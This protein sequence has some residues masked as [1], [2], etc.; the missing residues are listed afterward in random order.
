MARHVPWS[1]ALLV[2]LAAS[3]GM[4]QR[5][6]SARPASTYLPLNH[7]AYDY[8]NLLGARGRLP[9]L[10]PLVQPYRRV[11]VVAALLRAQQRGDLS[12]EERAWA[13]AL[14]DELALE[15]ELVQG[16][17]QELGLGGEV[18]V[19]FKALSQRHRDPLRPEGDEAVFGTA[20]VILRGAVPGVAGAFH[21]RWDNHYLNDPQFPGGRV[22]EVRACDPLIAECAYRIEEAYLELQAPYVRLF[23]GRMG[24]NWGLPG[25]EG[26]LV[27]N[28]SYTYD[29]IGYRFGNERLAITGLFAP[30]SD[31]GGDTIRYF[32]S[33]RLDWRVR[34]NLVLSAGESVL[35]GGPGQRL[36]LN[37]VNPVNVWEIGAGSKIVER[38]SIGMTEVWWRPRPSVAVYWGLLLDNTKFG[39]PGEASGLTQ[40]GTHAGVQFP[41]VGPAIALRADFSLVNSLAYRNR[42]NRLQFYTVENLGL[43]RDK[44]DAIIASLQGAWFH[45]AELVLKPQLHVMWRGADDI[46]LPWPSDAFTGHD[47]LLV[48]NVET[49]IRPALAGRWRL[50][51]GELEW[52]AGLNL[53]KNE[54]N[55]VQGWNARFVARA[56][57][58]LRTRF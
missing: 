17:E 25:A 33:H 58:T 9:G 15:V 2:T 39:D 23:L 52:D 48:G 30:L 43:G 6:G 44:T 18:N 47:L 57:L 55:A 8:V 37:F 10:S 22:I 14:T 1:L 49:T 16:R 7:W 54:D 35:Y 41:R 4:A 40:W 34:D 56:Q 13:D 45:G 5:G 51:R 28:Y 46:R 21:A 24:R 11:D 20:D 32:S 38:N 27:S 36:D 12:P 26:F 31:F 42:V 29:H 50:P 3:P 53:I 19:G